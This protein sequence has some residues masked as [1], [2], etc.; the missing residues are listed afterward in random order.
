MNVISFLTSMAWAV[1]IFLGFHAIRLDSKSPVNRLFFLV[2][3]SIA[4]WAVLASLAFSADTKERFLF[5]FH[6]GSLFNIIFYPLTVHF[7]LALT[8]LIPLR[9]LVIAGI[10]A[11]ALPIFYRTTTGNILFK[12]FVKV[13]DYWEF[14]PDYGSPWL[15]YVALYYFICMMAGAVC[16][17]IWTRRAATNK[18]RR[19]GR[20]IATAMLISIVIVT[21]DEIFL[22]KLDFYNTKAISPILFIIWMG[23]IWYAIVRYQ[24]LKITPAVVSE[25]IIANIDE[26]FILMDNEFRII[27]V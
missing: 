4:L 8:K 7:C 26:S 2:C 17:I 3:L 22:S 10:Y 16:F 11:P 1:Y 14:L 20:I 23:G 5:W 27:R 25:C 13:G 19:Q 21:T 24:F 15:V 18:Q 6:L 12:D 9:A